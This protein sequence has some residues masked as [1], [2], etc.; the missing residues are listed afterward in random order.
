MT[1][2]CI[3]YTQDSGYAALV[4]PTGEIPLEG[5]IA[6]DIPKGVQYKVMAMNELPDDH[7]F[8]DAWVLGDTGIEYDMVKAKD[9]G[10]AMRRAA[11]A[12]EFR[13]HDEIIMKQIPDADNAAAEEAR[14]R[15]RLKYALIQDA[16][17]AAQSTDEIKAALE[18]A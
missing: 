2:Q 1:N 7:I 4:I 11:R 3:V 12:E 15:I 13:P 10:H 5:V 18:A 9:I 17:E 16:I 14:Q 6:K 8:F